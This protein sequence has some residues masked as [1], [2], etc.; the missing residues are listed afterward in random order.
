MLTQQH[1]QRAR[2]TAPAPQPSS[3]G[4]SGG[5]AIPYCWR[6]SRL[7]GHRRPSPRCWAPPRP[8]SPGLR[9]L[10]HPSCRQGPLPSGSLPPARTSSRMRPLGPARCSR[11][12]SGWFRPPSWTRDS[13]SR[14]GRGRGDGPQH[15]GHH[16]PSRGPASPTPAFKGAPWSR[17]LFSFAVT[18]LGADF[19]S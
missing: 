15:R 12:L 6:V 3:P 14:R 10:P 5:T 16:C 9:S 4:Q 17:V 1:L 11:L 7:R 19:I 18:S 2:L 8:P 13:P